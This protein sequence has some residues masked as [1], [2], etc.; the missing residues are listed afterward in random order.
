[1]WKEEKVGREGSNNNNTKCAPGPFAKQAIQIKETAVCKSMEAPSV[2][3]RQREG[4]VLLGKVSRHFNGKS[5]WCQ[6]R[7]GLRK[8]KYIVRSVQQ[9]IYK[10]YSFAMIRL[11]NQKE[12]EQHYYVTSNYKNN[13]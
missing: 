4:P 13:E 9:N 8:H 12:K 10:Q 11:G 6:K 1:M 3:T 7:A 2:R 5:K